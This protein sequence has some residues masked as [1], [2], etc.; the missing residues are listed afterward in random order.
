[1]AKQLDF[2]AAL[3]ELEQIVHKLEEGNISLQKSLGS[4]EEGVKLVNLCGRELE[5]AEKKIEILLDGS[6]GK[7]RRAKLDPPIDY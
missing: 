7:K 5:A 2:E 6:K 3:K 4:F 1:M